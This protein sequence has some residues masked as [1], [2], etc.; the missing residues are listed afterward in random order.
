MATEHRSSTQEAY[1]CDRTLSDNQAKSCLQTFH[2]KTAQGQ[3]LIHSCST[4]R[5]SANRGAGHVTLPR[6]LYSAASTVC[7]NQQQNRPRSNPVLVFTTTPSPR[8][9][10]ILYNGNTELV[11][12]KC[13]IS[14]V[15]S[16][17][18]RITG[19]ERRRQ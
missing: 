14:T 2:C 19:R 4:I 5:N 15:I 11:V 7:P 16:N 12:S 6:P 13:Y 3:C 8:R 1:R 18:A 9:V 17:T 10:N